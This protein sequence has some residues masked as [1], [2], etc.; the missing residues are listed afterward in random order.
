MKTV[1]QLTETLTWTLDNDT[2]TI[3]GTGAMPNYFSNVTTPWKS[4][5]SSITTIN[6]QNGVTTIGNSAFYGCSSL[7]SITIPNSVTR[8]GSYAFENCISLASITIPNSVITIG[9]GAFY[10]CSSL[11]SITIPNSVT[12]IG[13]GAFARCRSLTSITVGSGNTAYVSE[14]G[15]LLD[16]SKTIIIACSRGKT[17]SYNIPNSVTTIGDMAFWGC[18]NL[19]SITIPNSVTNIGN[20]AFYGCISLTSITVSSGNTAYASEDGVLFNKSKT[21]II[22]YPAGK[23]G[24]TYNIPNSV[25]TIGVG[26]FFDCRSLT[27]ITIPNSVTTIGVGAF[28]SCRSLTSITIPNSVITIGKGAFGGCTSLRNVLVLKTTP[29]A[30]GDDTFVGVPLNP[31]TLTVPKGSKAA[32]QSADGWNEFGS[33]VEA[34]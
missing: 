4:H 25:T 2:L 20:E 23:T 18:S 34:N 29:P 32:Y 5:L 15:V 21:G 3:G 13:V 30:L 9:V 16:K 24:S 1:Q 10:N 33:I 17:G 11:T 12:T 14:N 28:F 22:Q 19:T 27:S 7:T 6:V 26:A 31:A 8:I